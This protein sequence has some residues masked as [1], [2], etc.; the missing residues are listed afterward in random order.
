MPRSTTADTFSVCP[1]SSS[2]LSHQTR[3]TSRRENRRIRRCS[4]RR[5][6]KIDLATRGRGPQRET[7]R[8]V[9]VRLACRVERVQLVVFGT[10]EDRAVGDTRRGLDRPADSV[11]PRLGERWHVAGPDR[12]FAGVVARVRR[13]E[14]EHRPITRA[15]QHRHRAQHHDNTQ[16][17]RHCGLPFG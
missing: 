14:P 16:P 5:A 6:S 1:S 10:D 12:R 11:P 7:D 2:C 4:R 13:P 8:P 3:T 17:P 15:Q 9:A